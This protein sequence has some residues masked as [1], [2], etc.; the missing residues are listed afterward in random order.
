MG[1]MV[2]D[3]PKYRIS[4]EEE[5]YFT[6]DAEVWEKVSERIG[7][8][9]RRRFIFWLWPIVAG[10]L[11]A[12]FLYG[13]RSESGGFPV[14]GK[15][16]DDAGIVLHSP[17]TTDAAF[18]E[19]DEPRP[20]AATE[21]TKAQDNGWN[22][23]AAI[24]GRLP[25][26]TRAPEAGA[27]QLFFKPSGKEADLPDSPSGTVAESLERD[28]ANNEEPPSEFKEGR[29]PFPVIPPLPGS[30]DQVE[31][32]PPE[33]LGVNPAFETEPVRRHGRIAMYVAL[34]RSQYYAL[35]ERSGAVTLGETILSS[36]WLPAV[37]I[38][39][40]LGYRIN[41]RMTLYAGL[42][43]SRHSVVTVHDLHIPY[44]LQSEIDH[45]QLFTNEF[46]HSLPTS[47]SNIGSELTLER[48]AGAD[49]L[50]HEEIDIELSTTSQY[51]V[52]HIP[53]SLERQFS[54]RGRF[55][56][57]IGLMGELAVERHKNVRLNHTAVHHD[58]VRLHAINLK[59][60]PGN[61]QQVMIGYGIRPFLNFAASR[62][63][64]LQF[65]APVMLWHMPERTQVS[66]YPQLRWTLNL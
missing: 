2:R 30:I 60:E 51:A 46:V 45:G 20:A 34:H 9:R 57:G 17:A 29:S 4:K 6:P 38:S 3:E 32:F 50:D 5:A 22:E 14:T 36:N 28:A 23:K 53:V 18:L 13:D 39:G 63:S 7:S 58:L 31:G 1:I 66:F 40:G 47:V 52:W 19:N 21:M 35:K 8:R 37:E 62:K 25:G 41:P 44:D 27:A 59:T 42:G 26:Q 15:T 48:S 61:R 12:L 64:G 55:Q 43:Y 11:G 24:T 10:A 56:P 65:G 33:G 54:T 16:V 49:I